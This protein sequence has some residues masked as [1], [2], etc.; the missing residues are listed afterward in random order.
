[1]S[2][3]DEVRA[4]SVNPFRV[5]DPDE[6]GLAEWVELKPEARDAL[7]ALADAAERIHE[8]KRRNGGVNSEEL[9]ALF[10]ALGRLRGG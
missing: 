10:A 1:M 3:L 9:A 2:L 8:T 7:V 4:A 5:Y 6:L